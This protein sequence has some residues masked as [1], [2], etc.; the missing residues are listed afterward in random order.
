MGSEYR[1]YGSLEDTR[2]GTQVKRVR[3][4]GYWIDLW[5]SE[6]LSTPPLSEYSEVC[7]EVSIGTESV[8][9][10]S[11]ATKAKKFG[12]FGSVDSQE[13]IFSVI[14][15]FVSMKIVPDPKSISPRST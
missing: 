14:E 12:F 2:K 11:S 9:T 8:L 7:V 5:Q 1:E 6:F 13:S 4:E 3:V 15:E 10:S